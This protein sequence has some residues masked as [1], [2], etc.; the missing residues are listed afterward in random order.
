[1]RKYEE[2]RYLFDNIKDKIYPW[3]KESLVD[4]V[5][6]NGK[7]ISPKDTPIVSFVGDLMIIFVIER[8]E[9]KFEILKDNMLPP[10]T[11]IEALYHLACQNLV[12]DV[13][14][15]ISNTMY[16]GFGILADGHHE[17]SSLCFKHI[18]SLCTDKLNDD[19]VI[20]VPVKDMVLFVPASN[21]K[22]I[23][24]MH[25]YG[26]EAYNR[27]KD[28]ISDKLYRFTKNEKELMVYG[29]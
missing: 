14:F 4:H 12:R 1:M 23:A 29:S 6:L 24:D 9:D 13:K 20:M 18:W 2:E 15:V 19:L 10:D 11:D 17:A 3:V 21:Q 22:Q 16:G 8:G 7:Y 25:A 5:A 27:N 26:L 28:K